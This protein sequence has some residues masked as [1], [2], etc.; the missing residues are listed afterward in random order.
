AS[1][2]GWAAW[3]GPLAPQAGGGRREIDQSPDDR[4][5]GDFD[6]RV[7][8]L[9]TKI[10]PER[11]DEPKADDLPDDFPAFVVKTVPKLG[12]LDVDPETTTEIRVTFSRPMKD[13]SWSWTQGNVYAFPEVTG[14]IH[15][16]PDKRTCVMPVKLE[17]GNTYVM[18]IN[19]GRSENFKDEK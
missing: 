2:A 4:L 9:Q 16:L 1:L 15:Y 3:A 12:D 7:V 11:S 5:R 17:P 8:C 13:Q 14:K 6:G 19:G 10:D 18:G